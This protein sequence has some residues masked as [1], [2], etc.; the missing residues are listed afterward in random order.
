MA[1]ES[2]K[3]LLQYKWREEQMKMRQR[4]EKIEET[5]GVVASSYFIAGW[6]AGWA[7]GVENELHR[8]HRLQYGEEMHSD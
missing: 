3:Y 7:D 4:A 1:R 8:Q 5:A 2:D 6:Y